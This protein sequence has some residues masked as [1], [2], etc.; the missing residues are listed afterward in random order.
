M[1]D[2]LHH[3]ANMGRSR[4]LAAARDLVARVR[5]DQDSRFF[6]AL[7]AMLE[8]LPPS[9]AFTGIE[10]DGEVAA[11]GSDFETLENLR[12]LA[13]AAQVDVPQQLELWRNVP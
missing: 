8:V 12:R 10:L 3:A 4:T 2:T 7:E 6:A 1:I 11:S 5:L 13:Y 9:A